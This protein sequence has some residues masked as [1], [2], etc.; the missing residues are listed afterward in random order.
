MQVDAMKLALHE[1]AAM[2]SGFPTIHRC[3]GFVI[4]PIGLSFT[5]E[6]RIES[7]ERAHGSSP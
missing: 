4:A 7:V 2:L 6:I 5:P 3:P 1:F